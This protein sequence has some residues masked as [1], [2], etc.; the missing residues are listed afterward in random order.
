MLILA[1]GAGALMQSVWLFLTF[2]PGLILLVGGLHMAGPAMIIVAFLGLL[3]PSLGWAAFL[4]SV[5][6]FARDSGFVYTVIE[7]TMSFFAGVRIPLPALPSWVRVAGLLF[8]LTTSLVILR[9]ALLSEETLLTL[10]PQMLF[11]ACF[12]L[13]MLLAS[14]LILKK[15][16]EHSRK[17]GTLTLF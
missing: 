7:S 5:C 14:I 9:G 17:Y 1:N 3:L 2:S 6:I 10:W 11:L 13:L 8:P 16:E 15:G 4:N 12:T